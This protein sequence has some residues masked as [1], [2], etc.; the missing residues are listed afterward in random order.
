MRVRATTARLEGVAEAG[1]DVGE[2]PVLR[3]GAGVREVLDRRHD[4]PVPRQPIA[5]RAGFPEQRRAAER[6]AVGRDEGEVRLRV[7]VVE[8]ASEARLDEEARRDV[9]RPAQAGEGE[10]SVA[11][12]V[13]AAAEM[14]ARN[15]IAGE[16]VGHREGFR[17]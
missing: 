17:E 11:A 2:A 8:R 15:E 16:E 9:D 10:A 12:E 3:A 13:E 1:A 14:R 7:A 4:A 6:A 5:N